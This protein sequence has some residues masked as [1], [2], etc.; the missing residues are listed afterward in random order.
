MKRVFT[1]C[2]AA[3]A[4]SVSAV[5]VAAADPS[6]P[7]NCFGQEVSTGATTGP[8]GSLGAFIS[9]YAHFFNSM[10]TS[11]GATGIPAAK[12]ACPTPPLPP[13]S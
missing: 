9:G 4:L 13:P 6:S 3:G 5:S 11:L 1:V 8:P 10:G 12:A 7:P 2:I